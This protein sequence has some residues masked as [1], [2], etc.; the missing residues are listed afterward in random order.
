MD[1][2]GCSLLVGIRDGRI[3]KVKGDPKG[4]LNK[5]YICSK[6]RVTAERLNHPKRLR[7][8]LKRRGDRGAGR[9]NSISWA[10]AIGIIKDQLNQIKDTDG[11]RSVAFCQGMPKGLEHFALIRLANVFG[12]PPCFV[13]YRRHC[14]SHLP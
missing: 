1:H 2:G 4:V 8:P 5:G 14:H 10:D 3:V 9:W 12:S 11:A 13:T 7:Y 6:G